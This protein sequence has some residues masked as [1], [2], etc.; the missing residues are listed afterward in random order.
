MG[1]GPAFAMMP[2]PPALGPNRPPVDTYRKHLFEL[3]TGQQQIIESLEATDEGPAMDLPSDISNDELVN[4][5]Q[6]QQ[7]LIK[8]LTSRNTNGKQSVRL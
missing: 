2:P 7:K 3:Y 5:L 8:A 6:K 1:E 4:I